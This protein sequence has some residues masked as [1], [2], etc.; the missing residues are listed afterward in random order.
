M[1]R[2]KHEGIRCFGGQGGKPRRQRRKRKANRMAPN[3]NLSYIPTL[4]TALAAASTQCLRLSGQ[5]PPPPL[6]HQ[7][8]A[9]VWS[10]SGVSVLLAWGFLTR[11]S[12]LTNLLV[13]FI[14]FHLA[15]LRHVFYKMQNQS[16]SYYLIRGG[17]PRKQIK[18]KKS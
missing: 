10:S 14:L 7:L 11:C 18:S 4:S 9:C 3:M 2:G 5:L 17:E 8:A 13:T 12:C 1:A 16:I 6:W 15:E